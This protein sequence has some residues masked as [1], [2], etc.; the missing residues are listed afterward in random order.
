MTPIYADIVVDIALQKLDKHF[1]Y[2]VPES[3]R[4]QIRIGSLVCVPFGGGNRFIKGYVITLSDATNA[5][6][7]KLKP[8]DS[9]LTDD[10]T[11]S[12]NLLALA[13]SM[14]ELYGG[15]LSQSLK[16]V[17]PI[18][19][20]I[21]VR[22]KELII[23]TADEGLANEKI[24]LFEKK[25]QTA[26]LRLLT[27]LLVQK[28]I[29]KDIATS[30]LN[31]NS[32][33][34]KALCDQQLCEVV[35][36]K[37]F[38]SP[39]E[40]ANKELPVLSAEQQRAVDGIL[41]SY[42][43]NKEPSIQGKTPDVSLLHGITGSGKTEVYI[44]IVAEVVKNNQQAIVLIPEIA[45]SFQT[46]MRFYKRFGNRVA[47][48]HSKLSEG[49]RYEIFRQAKNGEIDVVVGPRSALFTPFPSL[50]IIIMDEEHEGS[51]KSE[52][53][54][55]YHAREIAIKRA[56][57]EGTCVVLGSATPSIDSYYKARKGIYKLY[58]MTT[59]PTGGVLPEVDV[60][61]LKAELRSG[62]K[63]MFSKKL[64][65][66]ISRRLENNEQSLLF[67]N[68]RGY[69]GFVSCRSCG[70]VYRCPH[71]DVSLSL[72]GK[73]KMICHYCGYTVN[74][75]KTCPECGSKFIGTM[76]SG[77]QAVEESLQ[78]IF[79]TAR[80]LRMD[81]DT[82]RSKDS[83]EKILAQFTDHE[84]DIL[85]GT[86][87]II[88]GHDFP[89]VT[90]VGILMAD[91]SLY[92]GDYRSSER[93]F[94]ML[95]QC[96]GRAGRR[97]REGRV[98]IQTYSPENETVIAASKQDYKSFYDSEIMYRTLLS[99]PPSGHML[100]MLFEDENEAF[101]DKFAERIYNV[102]NNSL[103]HFDKSERISLIGP[104]EAAISYI[105]DIHR[106][107]LYIKA[108]KYDTLI[109]LKDGI[110]NYIKNVEDVKKE[111]VPSLQFDFDPMDGY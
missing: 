92:S 7:D 63:T 40:N 76:K 13:V 11:V 44:E 25:H 19:K 66:E 106:R 21:N 33:V 73:N 81:S 23:L 55:K 89:D 48:I 14:K 97:D 100:L 103:H 78:S 88:K 74:F 79:P 30:K 43:E 62:N 82:T 53:T 17:L 4:T 24:V 60:V 95:T 98:I 42:R 6:V 68:R 20:K 35:A 29:P 64:I 5:P 85:I 26:R 71:C 56:E 41:A 47:S 108:A 39:I 34:V 99:Y 58:E 1:T 32:S 80:I 84:A 54:P 87:M 2:I 59:R 102:I 51:Y 16:V 31:L 94:Q 57:L 69:A 111:H 9:I 28:V 107:V 91:M 50:G 3:L 83:Y 90:L 22:Q 104:T 61:D 110:E 12:S 37:E 77:T 65:D 70:Y 67:I 72:H 101:L 49:E 109:K 10:A 27:E 8:I 52:K 93:T 86:Q 46:L 105:K 96:A 45:L 38:A 36:Q 18:K 15:T 75:D